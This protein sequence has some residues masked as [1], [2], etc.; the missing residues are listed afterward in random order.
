MHMRDR[1]EARQTEEYLTVA[2]LSQRIAYSP[3]SIR[4][5]MAR[6]IFQLGVHYVKPRRRVLFLWSRIETWL[7]GESATTDTPLTRGR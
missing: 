5:M 3:Q 2:Q 6:G 1:H 7:H 4:N